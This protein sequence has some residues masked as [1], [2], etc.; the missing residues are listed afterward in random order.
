M[1]PKEPAEGAH[2]DR[3]YSRHL[4]KSEPGDPAAGA[5]NFPDA[6]SRRCRTTAAGLVAGVSR[7]GIGAFH[8][9]GGHPEVFGAVVICPAG[10]YFGT[11]H[12]RGWSAWL[13]RRITCG[14][15]S[16]FD[17]C[18]WARTLRRWSPCLCTPA[19]AGTP[20]SVSTWA[21]GPCTS[22]PGRGGGAMPEFK[23]D[24]ADNCHQRRRRLLGWFTGVLPKNK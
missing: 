14:G 3:V 21:V 17:H 6:S 24:Q 16:Q 9:S 15:S 22:A 12:G 10:I 11:T 23:G 18:V 20:T 13:R 7:G 19:V 2:V 5:A 4:E 8:V 1:T